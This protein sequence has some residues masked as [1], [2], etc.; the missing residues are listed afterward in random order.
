M[1]PNELRELIANAESDE[2]R[3]RLAELEARA[4][5]VRAST[6]LTN[7]MRTCSASTGKQYSIRLDLSLAGEAVLHT[8]GERRRGAGHVAEAERRRRRHG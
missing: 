4:I 2:L 5:Q 1:W 6:A 8:G 3:A 7:P